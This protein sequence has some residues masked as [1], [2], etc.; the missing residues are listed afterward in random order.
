MNK[1]TVLIAV[2]GTLRVGERNHGFAK[3]ALSNRLCTLKGTLYDTG[4]CFPAFVPQGDN[5]VAAELIE[6]TIADWAE[7]DRLEGYPRLYDRKLILVTL[8]DNT[9][10]KAWT[11]IMNNLPEQAKVIASGDWKHRD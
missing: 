3:N 6:V 7:I 9:T 5:M 10:I 1:K 11:Y 8:T 4:Y 2:Y